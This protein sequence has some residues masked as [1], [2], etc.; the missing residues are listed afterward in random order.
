M[1]RIKPS[2][3]IVSSAFWSGPVAVFVPVFATLP[4][5]TAQAVSAAKTTQQS[6]RANRFM[7]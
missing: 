3:V 6:S 5:G 7:S 4:F 1:W 2:A